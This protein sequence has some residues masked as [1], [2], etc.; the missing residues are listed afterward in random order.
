MARSSGGD[1]D[2]G[3]VLIGGLAIFLIYQMAKDSGYTS[4]LLA[5]VNPLGLNMDTFPTG[6]MN[7]GPQ[8]T[9][10]T[11]NGGI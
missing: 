9:T 4:G 1:L 2:I 6:T 7:V 8:P 5:S 10:A 3:I 11:S